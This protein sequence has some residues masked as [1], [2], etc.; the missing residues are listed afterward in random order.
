VFAL[1][2]F[3][4]TDWSGIPLPLNLGFLGMPACD[5][6]V[7]PHISVGL[8]TTAFGPGNGRAI[9]PV[10]I[11]GTPSLVG[12]PFFAQWYVVDPGPAPVPGAMTR[13]LAMTIQA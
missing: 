10:P 7:A 8:T 6:L 12:L 5:L 3:S 9:L 13:G 1:L 11:P 4:N 2:G